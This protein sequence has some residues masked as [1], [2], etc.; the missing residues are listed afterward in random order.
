MTIDDHYFE[1]R[2][3]DA[4]GSE[5]PPQRYR[6]LRWAKARAE[7]LRLYGDGSIWYQGETGQVPL[8][9]IRYPEDGRIIDVT[10]GDGTTG[11]DNTIY[12]LEALPSFIEPGQLAFSLWLHDRDGELELY[13]FWF[14]WDDTNHALFSCS[15]GG[16][17]EL[18]WADDEGKSGEDQD[19]VNGDLGNDLKISEFEGGTRYEVRAFNP[20][21]RD[22][23]VGFARDLFRPAGQ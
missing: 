7:K 16:G 17:G 12:P 5:V 23:W 4:D 10:I 11:D 6:T 9:M 15:G 1:T 18:V 22:S 3:F 19:S 8:E 20:I 13:E 2:F 14:D 21:S